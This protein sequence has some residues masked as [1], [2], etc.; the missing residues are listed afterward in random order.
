MLI[1]RVTAS[2]A[3]QS[4]GWG[5]WL[6]HA[7]NKI[8]VALYMSIII[9]KLLSRKMGYKSSSISIIAGI[10]D[11]KLCIRLNDLI[12]IHFSLIVG[13]AFVGGDLIERLLFHFDLV[14]D[15]VD[16]CCGF[17][18]PVDDDHHHD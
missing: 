6:V 18:K 13:L 8:I 17:L 11:P 10:L 1:W 4:P 3:L 5:C 14:F 15:L 2:F 16:R 9:S 7:V 12:C